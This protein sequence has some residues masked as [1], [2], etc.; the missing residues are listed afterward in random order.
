M[1]TLAYLSLSILLTAS[2]VT[3]LSA[4]CPKDSFPP[5]KLGDKVKEKDAHFVYTEI[6]ANRF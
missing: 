2:P 6:T 5:K 3:G 4:E 1:K